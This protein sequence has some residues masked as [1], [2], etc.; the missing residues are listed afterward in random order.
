MPQIKIRGIKPSEI[1]KVSESLIDELVLVVNCPRDYFEIEVI[2]SVAIR[3]SKEQSAYPFIE[4]AWFDRGQD[5]QDEVARIITLVF[6]EKLKI[7]N[8]D[9][10]FVN[11]NKSCYYENGKH[12]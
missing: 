10:A 5:I 1:C 8:L 4:I 12:F 2:N 3:D 7:E 6:K 11:F 9:L